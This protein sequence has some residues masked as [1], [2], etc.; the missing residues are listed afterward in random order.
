M[1]VT[2]LK[3]KAHKMMVRPTVSTANHTAIPTE[4]PVTLVNYNKINTMPLLCAWVLPGVLVD[5]FLAEPCDGDSS[6]VHTEEGQELLTNIITQTNTMRPSNRAPGIFIK[7]N[8][9][10]NSSIEITQENKL[11]L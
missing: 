9:G 2:E 5:R 7:Q 6:V 3:G 10:A 8:L 4:P 11:V 1:E